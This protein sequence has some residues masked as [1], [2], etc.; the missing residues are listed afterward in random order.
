M[1]Y[2]IIH[3]SKKHKTRDDNFHKRN[4]DSISKSSRYFRFVRNKET[5]AERETFDTCQMLRQIF[6]NV[7]ARNK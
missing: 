1:V 6:A 3:P 5:I 7:H 4:E 2:R